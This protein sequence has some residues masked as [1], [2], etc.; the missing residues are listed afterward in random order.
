METKP[1]AFSAGWL[2]AGSLKIE[3]DE[4]CSMFYKAP[5][6]NHWAELIQYV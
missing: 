5:N 2:L 6:L 1:M 4:T 3:A